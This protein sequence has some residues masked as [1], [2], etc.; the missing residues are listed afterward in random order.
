MTDQS[1][2]RADPARGQAFDD[3]DVAR[4]Y[5]NR[6]P[7][8]PELIVRLAELAPRHG[9]ALDL[10]CGP[11]KLARP[12]AD[13]FERVDAVDPAEPMIAAGRE[14]DDGVHQNVRWLVASAEDAQLHGPYDLVTAGAS[15]HWMDHQT[16]FPR[17][18]TQ[19][20]PDGI[21][22]IVGGDEAADPPWAQEWP[23]LMSAWISRMGGTYNRR[24]F[25]VEMCAHEAWM[26][27]AGRE[28]ITSTVSQTVEAFI[29]GEHSRGTWTRRKMGADLALAFDADLRALLSPHARDGVLTYRVKTL[30]TH[31]R[32]RSAPSY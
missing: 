28:T 20:T 3:I 22:A 5:A 10:G 23:A 32:P 4:A 29:D 21:V 19:M 2:A 1:I 12:L 11:G 13:L 14:L 9:A 24:T 8:P 30:L 26:D 31:G 15:I 7:Y 25:A 16:L 18:R 17:L 27:I 6:A